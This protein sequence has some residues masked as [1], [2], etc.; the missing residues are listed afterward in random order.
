MDD[1]VSS[2]STDDDWDTKSQEDP[3]T[4]EQAE[5]DNLTSQ[6]TGTDMSLTQNDS[7]DLSYLDAMY[8]S[9]DI[10]FYGP[11]FGM[12]TNKSEN[13]VEAIYGCTSI[14]FFGSRHGITESKSKVTTGKNIDKQTIQQKSAVE[15]NEFPV[16]YNT[17]KIL[18]A[19]RGSNPD[20]GDGDEIPSTTSPNTSHAGPSG[21]T[22]R[23]TNNAGTKTNKEIAFTQYVPITLYNNII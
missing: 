9:G 1:F 5:A 19:W 16:D 2:P 13:T 14:S 7:A 6:T 10:S 18:L 20:F 23:H 15:L 22:S 21:T 11:L 12:K 4:L 3:S 8:D 17:K